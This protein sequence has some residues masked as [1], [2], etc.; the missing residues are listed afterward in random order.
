[1]ENKISIS[2]WGD[3]K[4]DDTSCISFDKEVV[5]ILHKCDLNVINFEA[6][7]ESTGKNIRKSG[8]NL[9]QSRESALLL[10]RKGFNVISLANNHIMDF[11]EEG[12]K[13]TI[14]AF[15][16]C[17]CVGAGD[18]KEAYDVK[19]VTING[20]KIGFL[21]L[22]HCEFGTLYDEDVNFVGAAWICSPSVS[23][24]IKDSKTTVDYLFVVAHA[25]IEYMDIPLP[26]WRRVYKSF[27]D[28]GADG[29]IGTHPHVPQGWEEYKG[30]IIMYSLGNF[31]FQN[32]KQLNKQYWFSSL[33]CILHISSNGV[34]FEVKPITSKG[35]HIAVDQDKSIGNHIMRLNEYL[36]ND[37]LY[38]DTLNQY[39]RDLYNEYQNGFSASGYVYLG[40]VFRCV[41]R[42]IGTIAFNNKPNPLVLQ[43]IIRCESHRWLF[44]RAISLLNQK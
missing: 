39:C 44:L 21:S 32:K 43:N 38:Y 24:I 26:E 20:F 27:I 10:K 33:C 40:N 11:G 16:N 13:K 18:L 3:C 31:C 17:T 9:S 36:V 35:G 34:S 14:D 22:T 8:P 1:M 30:K 41:K 23:S 2:F 15:D 6:P 5:D 29:V 37:E 19:K 25:G 28:L 7:I 42:L 4:I 12:L